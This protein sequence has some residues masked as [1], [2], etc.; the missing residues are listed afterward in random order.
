MKT[1]INILVIVGFCLIGCKE[2]II[3]Q[4]IPKEFTND[5]LHADLVGK[6]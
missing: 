4:Q 1:L 5:L 3:E 2:T 6:E